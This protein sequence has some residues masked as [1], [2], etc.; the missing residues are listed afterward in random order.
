M[1]E[2]QENRD[3]RKQEANVGAELT[4]VSCQCETS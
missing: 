4:W 2:A 1:L 3:S